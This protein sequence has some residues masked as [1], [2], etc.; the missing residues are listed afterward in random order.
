MAGTDRT[1]TK[2]L[3]R[4]VTPSR[5][6]RL[7]PSLALTLAAAVGLA[8]ALGLA[9]AGAQRVRAEPGADLNEVRSQVRDLQHDA[10]SASERYNQ[11]RVDLKDV[12]AQLGS[13]RKKVAVQ[14]RAQAE[15][16]QAVENLARTLYMSG[17]VDPTLQV[18][19][20]DDPAAFLAQSSA[21]DYLAQSQQDLLRRWQTTNLRLAQ[22]E[23]ELADRQARAKA[24]T[25]DMKSANVEAQAKLDSAQGL[26]ANLTQAQR[27]ELQQQRQRERE[28]QAREAQEAA[29]EA[30]GGD[31]GQD[32][33]N[34]P[35]KP[36][37]TTVPVSGKA[38]TVVQY[39]LSQVGKSYRA[40][41]TGPD[42]FDCSG[43]V[44][45]AYRKVGVSLTHYSRAQF[46]QTKRIS[47]SQM[48]P[49]DLVFYFGR[50]AH[51]VAIYVGRGKM[52]S[53]SNPDDGV[54][55]IDFLGPWYRERFSGAGRVL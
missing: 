15:A 48:K 17:S 28:R 32:K 55:L 35:N 25:S 7:T 46:K 30:G 37:P 53:A 1:G 16:Q 27:E 14:R 21:M 44:L 19:L 22:A 8:T 39:A 11:A 51:H 2:A 49:G 24:L 52:V 41:R 40:A 54:E 50:G 29:R 6:L 45:A 47:V 33:P 31:A 12:T 3:T 38:A 13:I 26:L 10:E 9:T 4:R 23:A 18:L 34:K 43:L 5:M 42:S 36:K 20:T